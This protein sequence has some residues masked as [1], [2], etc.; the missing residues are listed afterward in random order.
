MDKLHQQLDTQSTTPDRELESPLTSGAPE[1]TKVSAKMLY[2]RNPREDIGLSLYRDS[3]NRQQR[4]K[5]AEFAS[6]MK[7]RLDQDKRYTAPKTD[8]LLTDRFE[9]E[10]EQ[11]I[12]TITT[13]DELT[14]GEF[15]QIV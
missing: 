2:Y 8:Q 15:N 13:K 6:K 10:L 9:R 3:Q 7:V 11:Q 14:F 12:L 1:T 4:H 5:L